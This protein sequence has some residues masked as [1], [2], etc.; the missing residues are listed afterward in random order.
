PQSAYLTG[1]EV[2]HV[3]ARQHGGRT[4][5]SN[6]ALSCLHCNSHKGPNIAGLDPLASGTRPVR[7]FHPR[8]HKWDRH[9]RWDGPFPAGRRSDGPPSLSWP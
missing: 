4:V 6:L 9:F 7:L 5:L 1:F 3:I 2:D 8:R